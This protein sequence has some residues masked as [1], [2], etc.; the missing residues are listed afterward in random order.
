MTIDQMDEGMSKW[1]NE[2]KNKCINSLCDW[3]PEH[4]PEVP[5]LSLCSFLGG[6]GG[7]AGNQ[8]LMTVWPHEVTLLLL[9]GFPRLFASGVYFLAPIII[10]EILC[11]SV[12]TQISLKKGYYSTLLPTLCPSTP[13]LLLN[14]A[15]HPSCDCPSYKSK[16]IGL[17]WGMSMWL[18][19][20]SRWCQLIILS[21][22]ISAWAQVDMFLINEAFV[23]HHKTI[24]EYPS[25]SNELCHKVNYEVT[26]PVS[27]R[28]RAGVQ[29]LPN[30]CLPD[31]LASRNKDSEAPARGHLRPESDVHSLRSHPAKCSL[32]WNQNPVS[33]SCLS[34]CSMSSL[35]MWSKKVEERGRAIL[36]DR[37]R[38]WPCHLRSLGFYL[39][40]KVRQYLDNNTG[41]EECRR[42]KPKTF[43]FP[44]FP[45][46]S[47]TWLRALMAEKLPQL[48]GSEPP[49]CSEPGN[50][51]APAC[52]EHKSRPGSGSAHTC[53]VLTWEL[54][55]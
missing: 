35:P 16:Y 28:K 48:L 54:L 44:A 49:T 33:L 12:P 10:L 26:F 37:F 5:C 41:S 50:Q 45:S 2:K 32:L 7:H 23:L 8:E 9:E 25:H 4:E 40:K 13:H 31:I 15:P 43:H 1:T 53:E 24:E 21:H 6:G 27:R 29:A 51:E 30:N 42:T 52:A 22:I 18:Q 39:S 36:S 19:L 47:W 46:C 34:L 55:H 3:K 38:P 20:C 14:P 11:L 17:L